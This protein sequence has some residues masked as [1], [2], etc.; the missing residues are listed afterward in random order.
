MGDAQ[1]VTLS[2]SGRQHSYRVARA[3][4][5]GNLLDAFFTSM[6]YDRNRWPDRVA[7]AVPR[8]DRWL[9]KRSLEGLDG[10][11]VVRRPQAELPEIV[12]RFRGRDPREIA[13]LIE[14]RDVSFDAWVASQLASRPSRA[15]WGFQ[16]S[17]A[18]SL[19]AARA[20]GK[21]AILEMASVPQQAIREIMAR[22]G[23]AEGRGAADPRFAQRADSEPT[24]ADWCI[25]ASSFCAHALASIGVPKDRIHVIALGADVR[26]FADGNRTASHTLR[27]LFLGKLGRHKG[28]RYLLEAM[29]RIRSRNVSL[30]LAGPSVGEEAFFDFGDARRPGPVDDVAAVFREHDVLVVPSLYEGFGLVIVEAMAAGIPVVATANTCAPDVITTGREGFVVPAFDSEAIAAKI[31]WLAGHPAQAR[32]MGAAAAARAADFSWERHAQRVQQFAREQVARA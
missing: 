3:L 12:A 1:L 8:L 22:E 14:K 2:H 4:Q 29:K 11:N 24:R 5:D 18:S 27:V 30:T 25:A 23:G 19:D 15:F 9:E 10:R 21:T 7:R 26:K 16:G 32:E 6:Y 31:D 13:G 28:L 20:S 17:C